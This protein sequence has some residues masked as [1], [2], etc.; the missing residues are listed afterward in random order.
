[1]KLSRAVV[2]CVVLV[3]VAGLAVPAVGG[4]AA[5]AAETPE[6]SYPLT[7]TDGTGEEVTIEEPPD[8]IVVMHASAAQVAHDIGQ[9]DNV[10]GAPVQPFT[11]Y[12]DDHDE[13]VDVTDEEGWPVIEVIVDLDPDLVLAGHVGDP[14]D[15]ATLRAENLTV[16]Q[17]PPPTSVDDIREKVLTYGALTDA[18]DGAADRVDWM[19]ERLDAI[20]ET[21][22]DVDDRP[23]AYYE[24]G[25]GWTTGDGT[26]QHDM[27]ERSGADN[28]G[29][30]AEIHG[31]GQVNEEVVI[32]LNPDFIVYGDMAEE[33]PVTDAIRDVPA[34]EQ[35]R[36]VA[37]DT[38]LI[39]QAGP[40][41]VLVMETMA[42]AFAAGPIEEAD[43]AE[44]PAD[45]DPPADDADDGEPP[46]DDT[47][48]EPPADDGDD[49]EVTTTADDADD[50]MP[51]FGPVAAAIALIAV[52]V[53]AHRGSILDR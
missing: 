5:A 13:P 37:V 42:E 36:T 40:R 29:A 16:Y 49:T 20:E 24:L 3:T 22:E 30:E 35:D 45:D 9:W 48:D 25:D 38:N 11:A 28:L 31:W 23:L 21:V 1:M 7:V 19:D 12:L 41:V 2:L 15:V 52:G 51:G 14:D 32:D 6:C 8:D 33:P 26:F 44:A 46:A 50:S 4:G 43:D 47:D 17:G 27:I 34:I 10:T 18:C 39:N 53:G